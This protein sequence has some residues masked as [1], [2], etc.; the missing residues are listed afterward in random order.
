MSYAAFKQTRVAEIVEKNEKRSEE[1]CGV[2]VFAGGNSMQ[3]S[4]Q[5][6][7]T[8]EKLKEKL[9]SANCPFKDVDL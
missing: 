5:N 4:V 8:P 7:L 2:I 1:E 6:W 3:T 9:Q